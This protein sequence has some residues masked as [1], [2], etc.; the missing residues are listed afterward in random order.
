M[1]PEPLTEKKMRER[2]EAIKERI[3]QVL[4]EGRLGNFDKLLLKRALEHVE[5]VKTDVKSAVEWF[6]KE[7]EKK[8]QEVLNLESISKKEVDLAWLSWFEELIKKAFSGVM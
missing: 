3:I 5:M 6:L 7:I 4:E 1:K 2:T 8:K